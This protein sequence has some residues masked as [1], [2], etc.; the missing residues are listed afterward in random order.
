MGFF[1][2][3]VARLT[4]NPTKVTKD[5]V[6]TGTSATAVPMIGQTEEGI[7]LTCPHCQRQYAIGK[8][9]AIVTKADIEAVASATI[10]FGQE[11]RS[12]APFDDPAL[13][14]FPPDNPAKQD[15]ATELLKK[16][17]QTMEKILEFVSANVPQYWS[18]GK[19]KN[20]KT[21]YAFPSMRSKS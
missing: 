12:L 19:C 14:D 21:P 9:A 7:V 3:I 20:E 1:K 6:S 17:V 13:V 15:H 10:E 16:S 8:N 11:R 4:A 5:D 18:C 2:R